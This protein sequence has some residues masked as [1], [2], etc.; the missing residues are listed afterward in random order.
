MGVDQPEPLTAMQEGAAGI[1]E[2]YRA[3]TGSGIPPVPA[4]VMLGCWLAF[5]SLIVPEGGEN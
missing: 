1:A 4:A 3:Y 2:L 5:G